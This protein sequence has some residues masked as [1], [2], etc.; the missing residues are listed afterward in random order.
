MSQ[1]IASKEVTHN[2]SLN[3][4]KHSSYNLGIVNPSTFGADIALT[5][6][7]NPVTFTLPPEVF[8]IH[9]SILDFNL[10]L[11]ASAAYT[12]YMLMFG[13]FKNSSSMVV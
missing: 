12:G 7:H 5:S 10:E 1:I 8:N 3:I 2:P 11:P 6:T 9:R 4:Y 13:Q